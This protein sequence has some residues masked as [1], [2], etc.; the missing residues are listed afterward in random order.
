MIGST[1]GHILAIRV[2]QEI[3]GPIRVSIINLWHTG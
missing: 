3:R 2:Y 1:T